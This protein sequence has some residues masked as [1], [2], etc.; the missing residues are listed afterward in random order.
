MFRMIGRVSICLA[1][2]ALVPPTASADDAGIAVEVEGLRSDLGS[3]RVA[4][5]PSEHGW[6]ERG[7]EVATCTAEVHHRQA[8]C[9][10]PDVEPGTYAIALLHDEDDDGALDRDFLGLPRE[11]FGFSNDAATSFGPPSFH[12]ASFRH[13]A[14]LT[15]LVV[16]ARY[17]I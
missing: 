15:E 6:V 14:G 5:Y 12:D 8:R 4:L 16:H 11:G 1:L 17:G 2:G 10:L 7:Y 13:D 9:V 3:V